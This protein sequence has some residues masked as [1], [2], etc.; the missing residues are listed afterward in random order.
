MVTFQH[1]SHLLGRPRFSD[2]QVQDDI[3]QPPP[4]H[5]PTVPRPASRPVSPVLS[6]ER[7]IR[8]TTP[9]SIDLPADRPTMPTQTPP[10]LSISLLPVD[11]QPNLLP[12]LQ[13]QR[14]RPR[15]MF[16]KHDH[17]MVPNQAPDGER[18]D[19]SLPASRHT[20]RTPGISPQRDTGLRPRSLR[21]SHKP[22]SGRDV[23]I[24]TRAHRPEYGLFY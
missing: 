10:D 8:L 6:P 16:T 19:P 5:P 24:T 23:A 4:G 13:R 22:S 21:T 7:P 1:S 3:P 20:R 17:T 15:L 11:P 9:T 14:I 2:Q 18:R 12:L